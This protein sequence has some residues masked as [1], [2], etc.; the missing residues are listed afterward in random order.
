MTSLTSS[1]T[2]ISR[3]SALKLLTVLSAGVGITPALAS[4]GSLQDVAGAFGSLPEITLFKAKRI[5]TMAGD[6]KE[7]DAVAVVGSR[8]LAVGTLA[9]LEKLAGKQP[10]R[11][12]SQ[13]TDKDPRYR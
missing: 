5:I 11:V 7:A 6:S 12:D 9:E 8:V 4:E 13:F 10:Y 3:R 1:R 2:T